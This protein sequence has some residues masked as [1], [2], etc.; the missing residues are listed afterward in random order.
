MCGSSLENLGI[1]PFKSRH[2]KQAS[3]DISNYVL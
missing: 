3:I 1:E 2:L